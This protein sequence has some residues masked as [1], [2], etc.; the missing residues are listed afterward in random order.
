MDKKTVQMITGRRAKTF[1]ITPVRLPFNSKPPRICS[2][3][4]AAQRIAAANIRFFPVFI[5]ILG[6]FLLIITI[7]S[8]CALHYYNGLIDF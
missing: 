7:Y 1:L 2:Y 4:V 3:A 6:L 5:Y 8:G